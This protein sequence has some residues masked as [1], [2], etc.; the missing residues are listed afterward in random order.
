MSADRYIVFKERLLGSEELIG[1]SADELRVLTVLLCLEGEKINVDE[2]SALLNLSRAR[3]NATLCLFEDG[4]DSR[5][6]VK[7]IST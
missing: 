1:A 6:G 5:Y 2:I 3:I 7:E 4:V